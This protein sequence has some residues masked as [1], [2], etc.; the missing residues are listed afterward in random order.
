MN[1]LPGSDSPRP[2]VEEHPIHATASRTQ[3]QEQS[4]E[5]AQRH[6]RAARS[7]RGKLIYTLFPLL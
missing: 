2:P 6:F 7:S 3:L 5:A 1:V 4:H